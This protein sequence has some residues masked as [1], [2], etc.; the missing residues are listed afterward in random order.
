M[1]KRIP[2]RFEGRFAFVT[3]AAARA[4]QIQN[5]AV[6]RLESPSDNPTRLAMKEAVEDLIDWDFLEEENP[7]P[8]GQKSQPRLK[9][10]V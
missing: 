5:G 6:P 8:H 7:Q 4:R 3:V 10:A 2:R 1:L 9:Q